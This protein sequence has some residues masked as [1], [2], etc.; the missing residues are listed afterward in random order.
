MRR[1]GKEEEG[2]T[3]FLFSPP[4]F[5]SSLSLSFRFL[6]P[7]F[8]WFQGFPVR[9][10]KIEEKGICPWDWIPLSEK[11]KIGVTRISR[12]SIILVLSGICVHRR[13]E[14]RLVGKV[15][16]RSKGRRRERATTTRRDGDTGGGSMIPFRNSGLEARYRGT[17]T[18]YYR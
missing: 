4:L 9:W 7:R 3:K 2:R 16:T 8:P 5:P 6:V 17:D 1:E 10:R 14:T 18:I 15:E 11:Q 12:I 13:R